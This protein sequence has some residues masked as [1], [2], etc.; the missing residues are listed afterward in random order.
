MEHKELKKESEASAWDSWFPES[1]SELRRKS[2]IT[3]F[4]H[5]ISG[6]FIKQLKNN[7]KNNNNNNN[8]VFI[9]RGKR[10]NL[11]SFLTY[12]SLFQ[13]ELVLRSVAFLEREKPVKREKNLSEQRREPTTNNVESH[14]FKEQNK[15][16]E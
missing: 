8:S 3:P 11:F 13:I 10:N 14:I 16:I 5:V 15:S 1:S 9:Q 2:P 4:S 7:N 12:G 6:H